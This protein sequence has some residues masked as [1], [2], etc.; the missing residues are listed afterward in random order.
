M[1]RI[2]ELI[3]EHCPDGVQEIVLGDIAQSVSGLS[4]KSKQDFTDGNSRFV[5]YKNV[6]NNLQVDIEKSE[7][8]QIGSDERQNCLQLGDVLFT[9]SSESADELGMSSVVVVE[10]S[11]PLYLNSFCFALRF[12][13]PNLLLPEFSKYLFRSQSVRKQ[14]QRAGN[15]VT[16]I[17]IS[18]PQFM[19]IRIQVPPLIVQKEIVQ[20]LDAMTSLQTELQAELDARRSQYEFYRDTLLS[21]NDAGTPPVRWMTLD[22]LCNVTMGEF[23]KK[24]LQADS[25][26]FPVY[27][28]GATP[29]GYYSK[30]N[31]P[32]NSVVISA[33]GS[34]GVVN[35]VPSKSWIGNSCFLVRVKDADLDNRFMYHFL[36][37]SE[38]ELYSRRTVGTLPALNMKPVKDFLV[39]VPTLDE[40]QRIV[41]ILDNFDALVNDI[42]IG[43]PAEIKARRQQYEY[44]RDQLLSFKELAA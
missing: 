37:K 9:A 40:Q 39:P 13:N 29:T 3:A 35:F 16:R 1:S 14:I 15:G 12:E 11:E 41:E 32:E 19:K 36:K 27:N 18:K 21:F 6:F 8:V 4:G 30:S 10:P 2:D 31:A 22:E 33:R 26:E 44:Y 17:N 23:V 25:F 24:T 34:I 5:T 7:F 42:S 20:T 28:G 38:P 43:L